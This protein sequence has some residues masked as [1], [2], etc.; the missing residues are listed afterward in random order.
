MIIIMMMRIIK[1]ERRR[2]SP[3][4]YSKI[5]VRKYYVCSALELVPQPTTKSLVEGTRCIIIT[6]IGN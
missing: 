1:T 4:P 3:F 2:V 5:P 6:F